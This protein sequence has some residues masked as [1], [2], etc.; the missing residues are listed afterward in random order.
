MTLGYGRGC[1]G[2]VRGNEAYGGT[3]LDPPLRTKV[4][5]SEP[6]VPIIRC[7]R[8]PDDRRDGPRLRRFGHHDRERK[9]CSN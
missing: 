8:P 4:P 5:T 9:V 2:E 6:S 7:F 1:R 3:Q